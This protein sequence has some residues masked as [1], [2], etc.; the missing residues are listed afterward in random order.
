M[1]DISV[2]TGKGRVLYRISRT[3]RFVPHRILL[4]YTDM[5]G[6]ARASPK[7]VFTIKFQ[8]N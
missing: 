5:H 8:K 3:M 4:L 6:Q 2:G 1:C 7:S